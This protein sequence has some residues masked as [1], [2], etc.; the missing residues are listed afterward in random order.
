MPGPVHVATPWGTFAVLPDEGPD[1][2]REAA[3]RP[4]DPET[5]DPIAYSPAEVRSA[6]AALVEGEPVTGLETVG[7]LGDAIGAI[8]RAF[9]HDPEAARDLVEDED[10]PAAHPAAGALGKPKAGSVDYRPILVIVGLLALLATVAGG[11]G[12]IWYVSRG[13]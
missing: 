8:A 2:D 7:Q 11:A 4:V 1:R 5:G 10:G 3:R 9:G 13:K 6:I 12:L